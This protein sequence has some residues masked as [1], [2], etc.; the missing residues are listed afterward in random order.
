MRLSAFCSGDIRPVKLGNSALEFIQGVFVS[1]AHPRLA[2]ATKR[3]KRSRNRYLSDDHED[4]VVSTRESIVN[5]LRG[6]ARDNIPVSGA[7]NSGT[8]VLLTA[9][10]GVDPERDAV[11][12]DINAN[13]ER[14]RL[15]LGS[16]R[17]V[18]TA[19][20]NGAKV[21][22]SSFAVEDAVFEGGRAFRVAVPEKLQRIQRRGA[23]RVGTPIT[24][25]V[26]CRI[27]VA[28][29]REVALPLVDICVEGVGVILP[30]PPEP[31]FEK[32]AQFKHCRLE[33]KEL[34]VAEL[35]LSVQNIWEVE[36]R[37]GQSSRRAGLEFIDIRQQDEPVIQR[38]VY[39]MEALKIAAKKER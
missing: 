15:F 16:P 32:N 29:D 34:G 35:T 39:R 17:V 7:F 6:L 23:Y 2:Q 33:H 36:L 8:E 21:Q 37:N 20:A 14:N 31:A 25:P 4:F 3:M 27:P 30:D 1:G 12:L 26:I 10:L 13:A 19:Q 22:W 9:V 11:Y 5:I 24:H 18:F 28:P 38:F